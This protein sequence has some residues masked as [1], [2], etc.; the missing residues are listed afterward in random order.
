M[1][2]EHCFSKDAVYQRTHKGQVICGS[3][4]ALLDPHVLTLM[5]LVN[6]FTPV[7]V[8]VELVAVHIPNA[9]EIIRQLETKGLI[10]KATAEAQ[11]PLFKE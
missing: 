10:E 4:P 5:R 9:R 8:L 2:T 6:G 11:L 1:G 3:R 7:S